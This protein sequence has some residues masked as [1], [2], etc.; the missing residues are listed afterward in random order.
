MKAKFYSY[1][2]IGSRDNNEDAYITESRDNDYLF[3]VADGLGGH[4]CGEVA[5]TL[6]VNKLK[7]LFLTSD[8]FCLT[9]AMQTA[10]I[11][12][13]SEQ[14]KTGKLMRTTLIAAHVHND[15]ITTA[16]AG[17]TRAYFLRDKAIYSRTLDHSA[18][19]LAVFAGEI[20]PDQI[21]QHP[22]RNILT[23]VLG[24]VENLKPDIYEFSAKKND[25]I[26]LCSDGFWEF[27]LEEDMI[28]CLEK[29]FTPA[30]WLKKMVAIRQKKAHNGSDNNT[31]V[32]V[33][34]K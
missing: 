18:S 23:K 19:Q 31:A 6:A 1:S 3:A 25:S 8:N 27:V 5:S 21:R 2:N 15:R 34:L 26:L 9:E 33:F 12:V 14:R 7:E 24:S 20:T 4:D 28:S 10:N 29:T 17:D 30:E 32:A 16:H 13:L 22:D 11:A